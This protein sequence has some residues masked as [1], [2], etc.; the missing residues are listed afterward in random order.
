MSSLLFYLLWVDIALMYFVFYM[1]G[2]MGRGVSHDILTV[3]LMTLIVLIPTL[4]WK[5]TT[6][7]K[8]LKLIKH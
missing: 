7:F 4:V 3:F 6:K 1:F 5:Y 8:K 2:F